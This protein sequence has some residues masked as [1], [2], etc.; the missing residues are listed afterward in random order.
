MGQNKT[1][2][3]TQKLV[4]AI[5]YTLLSIIGLLFFHW[6]WQEV[7]LLYW[8]E[9]VTAG[10]VNVIK[11]RRT[12][13]MGNDTGA[14]INGHEVTD[15]KVVK[16]GLAGF[17]MIHYGIFTFVHGM[18][19]WVIISNPIT[20]LGDLTIGNVAMPLAMWAVVTICQ[21]VG[22]CLEKPPTEELEKLF[23]KPYKRIIPLHVSLLVGIFAASWLG[24]PQVI[25]VLLV[26]LHVVVDII[27]LSSD[28]STTA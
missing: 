26:V 1:I 13:N 24:F 15:P 14:I 21:I 3:F 28:H 22:A 2:V 19:V 12:K 23:F 17:F 25:A 6:S 4:N 11:M 18:F 7:L 9:N 8:L 16:N 27:W 5:A 20:V 10:I